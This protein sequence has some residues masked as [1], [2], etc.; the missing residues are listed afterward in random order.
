[1]AIIADEERRMTSKLTND[2]LAPAKRRGVKLSGDRGWPTQGPAS[3]LSRRYVSVRQGRQIRAD[4]RGATG[5]RRDEPEGYC[6][7]VARS[8]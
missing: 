6:A 4:H 5:G 7:G 1:M 3:S 2:A 8:A